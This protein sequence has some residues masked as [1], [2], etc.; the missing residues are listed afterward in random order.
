MIHWLQ[1]LSSYGFDVFTLVYLACLLLFY[2]YLLKWY[3]LNKTKDLLSKL[4]QMEKEQE[5]I[6]TMLNVIIFQ[7]R[8]GIQN[9]E[10]C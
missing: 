2:H 7:F 6:K 1:S 4:N 5:K 10:E 8:K 3:I 9:D